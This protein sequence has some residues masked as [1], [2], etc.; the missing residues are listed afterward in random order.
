[1][2]HSPLQT[3]FTASPANTWNTICLSQTPPQIGLPFPEVRT[4]QVHEDRNMD[5]EKEG[6]K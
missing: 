4:E 2:G 5:K 3:P 6:I 1:M